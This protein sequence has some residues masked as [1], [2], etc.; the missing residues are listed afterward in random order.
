MGGLL[1]FLLP[2]GL[3]IW[4]LPFSVTAQVA[5]L[6]HTAIGLLLL[7]PIAIWLFRH[8]WTSRMSPWRLRKLCAYGGFWTL[9]LNAASGL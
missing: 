1:L 9:A 8:W 3:G 6:L 5:V 2:S 4:L 7:V